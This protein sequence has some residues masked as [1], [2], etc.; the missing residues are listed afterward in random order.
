M[1][2]K[3]VSLDQ[4]NKV[5]GVYSRK[6]IGSRTD[7][8]GTPHKFSVVNVQKIQFEHTGAGQPD[9]TG[10]TEAPFQTGRRRFL[11]VE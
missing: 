6:R 3:T 1:W 4:W 5:G 10:T 7:P 9:M 11:A 8:C 2:A